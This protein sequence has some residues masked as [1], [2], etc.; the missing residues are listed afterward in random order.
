V[1]GAIDA[2]LRLLERYPDEW[3]AMNNAG[4]R[5]LGIGRAAEAEEMLVR[6]IAEPIPGQNVYGNLLQAQW[7]VGKPEAAWATHEAMLE[8]FPEASNQ[9]RDRSWLLSAEGRWSEAHDANEQDIARHPGQVTAQLYGGTEITGA[10][11]VRGR[12]AEAMEHLARADRNALAAQASEVYMAGPAWVHL[13]TALALNDSPTAARE[14]L[15][16][17][18]Q[19]AHPE[20]LSPRGNAWRVLM[21]FHA[22]A[23]DSQ[24]GDEMLQQYE[25]VLAPQERGFQYRS[26]TAEY[27]AL[28]AFGA[29]D[30]AAAAAA[31]DIFHG[32]V[33]SCGTAC[34]HQALHGIALEETGRPVE[35]IEQYQAFLTHGPLTWHA[36]LTPWRPTVL[37]RLA[38][39]YEAQGDTDQAR[40]TLQ[41][42]VDQYSE[43]DG[44]FVAYVQRA[45]R[46]LASLGE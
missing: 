26:A 25:D 23:G 20:D 42:I 46:K 29:G 41:Q 19:I 17:I 8:A 43:G 7:N 37:E 34:I 11:L 44:P 12:Y 24:R 14:A 40:A 28:R 21:G 31:F 33:V 6:A 13:F 3:T 1:E 15:E 5:L 32:E 38:G 35:A 27:A 10:D 30:Y 22:L 9:Y 18:A 2:Y 16:H 45:R 36:Y 39:L 4:V